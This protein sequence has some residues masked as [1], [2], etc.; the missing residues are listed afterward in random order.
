MMPTVFSAAAVYPTRIH[1]LVKGQSGAPAAR[2]GQNDRLNASR[3]RNDGLAH[4]FHNLKQMES[5]G[6]GFELL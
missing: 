1:D 6:S 2:D 3:C 4:V 5:E